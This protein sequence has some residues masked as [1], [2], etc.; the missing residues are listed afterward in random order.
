MIAASRGLLRILVRSCVFTRHEE[1]IERV[2]YVLCLV[3]VLPLLILIQMRPLNKL[4]VAELAA[5]QLLL[6]SG[7]SIDCLLMWLSLMLRLPA[8]SSLQDKRLKG[9]GGL[10]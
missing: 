1:V 8:S 6:A 3:M 9:S 4:R 2:P 10:D 7:R 5:T